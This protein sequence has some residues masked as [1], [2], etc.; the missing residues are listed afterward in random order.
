M[1]C[2]GPVGPE[3]SAM[4]CISWPD[5]FAIYEMERK[6]FHF[7]E[8]EKIGKEKDFIRTKRAEFF[9]DKINKRFGNRV[10]QPTSDGGMLLFFRNN[11]LHKG[12]FVQPGESRYVSV[13]NIYPSHV[14]PDFIDYRSKGLSKTENYPKA[15]DFN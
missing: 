12:G 14:P 7:R 13:F 15:P 11:C 10:N 8:Y 9:E 2:L 6:S 3:N 1:Y 4:E 5:S